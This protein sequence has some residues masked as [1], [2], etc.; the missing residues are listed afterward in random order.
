MDEWLIP[1][2]FQVAAALR[3]DARPQ[4]ATRIEVMGARSDG[5][6]SLRNFRHFWFKHNR[7]P[8]LITREGG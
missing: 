7:A 4:A 2:G 5:L 3:T 1:L 6:D 8:I